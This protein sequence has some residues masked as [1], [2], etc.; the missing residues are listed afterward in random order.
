MLIRELLALDGDYNTPKVDLP[1]DMILPDELDE[2]IEYVVGGED[3]NA[4]TPPAV[5]GDDDELPE[6]LKGLSKKQLAELAIK[7]VS[8]PPVVQGNDKLSQTLEMLARQMQVNTQPQPANRAGKSR[9]EWAK[10]INE[11]IINSENPAEAVMALVEEK[12]GEATLRL[13][14]YLGPMQLQALRNNPKYQYFDKFADE[15]GKLFGTLTA[16]QQTQPGAADW[17]YNTTIAGHVADIV[18]MAAEEKAKPSEKPSTFGT[19]P[20][21]NAGRPQQAA[22]E[23]TKPK[24]TIVLTPNGA[25]KMIASQT[26]QKLDDVV[27]ARYKREGLF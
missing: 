8:A 10:E 14:S 18:K 3:G 16:E 23:V 11:K 17:A 21:G 15:I 4:V 7:A 25:D 2:E 26:G 1:E 12:L 27:R 19:L 24:R 22:G 5:G 13:G 6:S 20:G 9:E